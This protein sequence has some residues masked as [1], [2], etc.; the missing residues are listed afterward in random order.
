[1]AS[2]ALLSVRSIG[3]RALLVVAIVA[4]VS[5]G[6][7]LAVAAHSAVSATWISSGAIHWQGACGISGSH[8]S[9]TNPLFANARSTANGS[10][11]CTKVGTR[12][13]AVTISYHLPPNYTSH[14]Y[15]WAGWKYST[16]TNQ[17]TVTKQWESVC[18]GVGGYCGY[19]VS[20]AQYRT[21]VG[22]SYQTS[23]HYAV[24]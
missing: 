17:F 3:R 19:T 4:G 10:T 24:F 11:N 9:G 20:Y 6:S 23:T 2:D 7:G 5:L 21:Y 15:A 13:R 16:N 18:A 12:V 22:G 14:H 8:D 1:M